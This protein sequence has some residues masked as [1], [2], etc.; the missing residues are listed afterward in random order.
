MPPGGDEARMEAFRRVRDEMI[1]Q[2]PAILSVPPEAS[3]TK[4]S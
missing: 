4:P 1:R 3:K 2:A